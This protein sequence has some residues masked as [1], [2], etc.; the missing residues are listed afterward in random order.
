M[1]QPLWCLIETDSNGCHT[2]H[3]PFSTS[4]AATRHVATL[5]AQDEA[6][7][8]HRF[9]IEPLWQALAGLMFGE[10]A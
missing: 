6:T 5:K 1:S 9:E 7:D 4:T 2:I 3:G 8:H 10:S